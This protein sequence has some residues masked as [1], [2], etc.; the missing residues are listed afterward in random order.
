MMIMNSDNKQI[1]IKS[2]F[3]LFFA[4]CLTTS[5]DGQ[6]N[7]DTVLTEVTLTNAIHYAITKNP[8]LKNAGLQ[9]EITEATIRS[10]LAEWYPQLNF[11][12]SLQHNFQLPVANFN[13]QTITTGFQNTSGAQFGATQS[14]FNR[15]VLLASRTASDVRLQAL[16]NTTQQKITIA[17]NVSKAFYDII[18]TTQQIQV[19][20]EQISRINA[21]LKDAKFRYES[22]I[23]DKTD[24]K[25]AT[26]ALNNALAQRKN[27]SESLQGKY[28]Y[29]KELMG[30][31]SDK[32]LFLKYDTLQMK[33][34]IYID[35]L[36][37]INYN[38]RIEFQLLQTQKN[39]QHYNLQYNQWS[40]LP[41]VSAF[42]NYN[43]NFQNKNF[44]KVYS[45]AYPNSY[46][47]LLL[48][49][50]IYQG[51]KRQ[52]LV[53]Q[54]R[55]QLE[56]VNNS[57]SSTE[58]SINTQYERSLASYKSNLYSYLIQQDN[59]AIAKEVYDVIQL[60]YKSGIKSYIEV[61]NAE[62]DL[63]TAQINYYNALYQLLSSKIDVEQ[64][65]GNITY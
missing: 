18:L 5:T 55:L 59:M 19:T 57:I 32:D 23:V 30:Y 54:A 56:Q 38:N 34:E 52:Q 3:I 35:T 1:G 58:K 15:D 20:D 42:G 40:F 37:K 29:L 25:R 26:I 41:T 51:G 39:L 36:Q 65:L 8:S 45:Q 21:S 9:Q 10:K 31:P 49:F 7:D 44:A 48:S 14:I 27:A 33:S 13:G 28:A 63:R 17:A 12:Y 4:I 53:K 16:Q 11:N 2:I 50:P 62:S 43:L 6:R 46:A 61:I 60:Q 22:G 64:S 47:G 24:Y